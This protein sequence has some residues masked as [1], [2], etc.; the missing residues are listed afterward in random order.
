MEKKSLLH[1]GSLMSLFPVTFKVLVWVIWLGNINY[2]SV[3]KSKIH[4][5]VFLKDRVIHKKPIILTILWFYAS[6]GERNIP[7]VSWG[8]FSIGQSMPPNLW[9]LEKQ[10]THSGTHLLIHSYP[11][12]LVLPLTC[13]VLPSPSHTFKLRLALSHLY[14][15]TRSLSLRHSG[16]F[17]CTYILNFTVTCILTLMF[18]LKLTIIGMCS[19]S[20]TGSHLHT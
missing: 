13:S 11:H 6:L 7:Q 8:S 20:Y 17:S 12:G 1:P 3:E 15:Q 10:N 14:I 5:P 2:S 4:N 19:L 16:S 18:T 9:L